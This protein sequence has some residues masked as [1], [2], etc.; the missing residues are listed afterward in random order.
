MLRLVAMDLDGTLADFN[1]AI[2]PETIELL[3]KL[4]NDGVRLVLASGKPISYLAGLTRQLGLEELI[5]IGGNGAITWFNYEFPQPKTIRMEMTAAATVELEKVKKAILG[6]FGEKIWIQP[7]EIAFSLFAKD[8]PIQEVYDYCDRI[9][10]AEEIKHL[11]SFKTGGALDVVSLNIDKG[12]ALKLVQEE[13]NI[14]LEDTAVIGDGNNDI[15]MFLRG[16]LRLTFP[17]SAEIFMNLV[18]KIVKDIN[19]ALKFLLDLLQFE[20]S[21]IMDSLL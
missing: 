20:K 13:L 6:E 21:T 15:P 10:K 11:K 3:K 16:K 5:I 8:V 7:N 18:P 4:Q 14:H 2:Q 12:I 9:F 19:A 17:K 1:T